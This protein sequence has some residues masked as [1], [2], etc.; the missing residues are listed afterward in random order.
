MRYP[1][2]QCQL[3]R[4]TAVTY[5][6]VRMNSSKIAAIAIGN[7]VRGMLEN[8]PN[9]QFIVVT[10]DTKMAPIGIHP[11]TMGTL[12]ASLVHPR[13]VFRH[14]ILCNAAGLFLVHNHPS[15]DTTPSSED[16]AVT[17]R[18][19]EAGKILGINVY[20]HIIVG[21]R[22]GQWYGRSLEDKAEHLCE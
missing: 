19:R 15:G 9:E 14:P 4:Q 6:Y 18:L 21:H 5:P 10:S 2:Y 13:E 17:Q 1:I 16:I 11:V 3:V 7:I 20:D 12:D 8:S 22:D